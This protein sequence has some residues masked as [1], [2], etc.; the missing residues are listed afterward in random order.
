MVATAAAA[1]EL[2]LPT[3][4]MEGSSRARPRPLVNAGSAVDETIDD[5]GETA[6]DDAAGSH[7]A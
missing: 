3:A 6:E 1:V 7:N 2:M 4:M 5:L